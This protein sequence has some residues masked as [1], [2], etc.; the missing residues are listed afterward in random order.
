L[1]FV[2]WKNLLKKVHLVTPAV[3]CAKGIK[4]GD[5]MDP[6]GT[7]LKK[8]IIMSCFIIPPEKT[9]VFFLQ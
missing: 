9:D 8:I 3:S 4:A 6:L 7:H 2:I 5:T 1:I